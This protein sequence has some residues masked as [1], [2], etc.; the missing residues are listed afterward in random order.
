MKKYSRLS[1]A[2][3]AI[4]TLRVNSFFC[5]DL[6]FPLFLFIGHSDYSSWNS[7]LTNNINILSFIPTLEPVSLADWSL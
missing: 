2:A 6:Y 7:V 4:G 1:S 3:V 5:F